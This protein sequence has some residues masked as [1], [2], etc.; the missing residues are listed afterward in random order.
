MQLV[1]GI[2]VDDMNCCIS[3]R[4]DLKA[5]VARYIIVHGLFRSLI[6]NN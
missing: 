1:G 2:D 6:G 5:I 4:R 3:M